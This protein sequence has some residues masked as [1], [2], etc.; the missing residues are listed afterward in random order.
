M[1]KNHNFVQLF[2]RCIFLASFIFQSCSKLQNPIIPG[3][4]K[5]IPITQQVSKPERVPSNLSKKITNHP[6][7]DCFYNSL[8]KGTDM[9]I[10]AAHFAE[11][12]AVRQAGKSAPI[13]ELPS[14]N[15][16]NYLSISTRHN[17]RYPIKYQSKQPTTK[18]RTTKQDIVAKKQQHSQLRVTKLKQALLEK[19][20][21]TKD[22]Y[23]LRF[24]KE[25][26]LWKA[27]VIENYGSLSRTHHLPVYIAAGTD[28]LQVA[29]S[30]ELQQTRL[31]HVNLP[32]NKQP[33]YVYIG[34]VGLKGGGKTKANSISKV[35]STPAIPG[36]KLHTSLHIGT[37]SSIY[38]A[39]CLAD[40][41]PV[42]IKV[43][44][45]KVITEKKAQRFLREFEL[46]QQVHSPYV[47]RYLELKQDPAYGIAVVMED[48]QAVELSTIVPREG[49]SNRDFIEIALQIV[50]GLQAIHD[51]NIIHNDLKPSN[52]VIEPTTKAIKITD[53]NCASTLREEKRTAMPRRTGTLA[54]ISPEQTGRVNRSVDYRTDFYSLGITFYQLL[55]G[56]PPF[57]AKDALGLI[58]QHLAKQPIP[59]HHRK[60]TIALPL[61]QMVMKLLDKEAENRY[62]SC[63]GILHDLRFCL[64]NLKETGTIPEFVLG[65]QDF[66]NKLTL[67]QQLY[68]RE[69][70]IKTLLDAFERVREGKREGLMVTGQPGVGKTILIQ[71][72]QKPIALKQGYFITGKFDQ[73]N[74]NV[75]YSALTQAFNS[76]IQQWLSEDEIRIT[77]WKTRLLVTLGAQAP[78]LTK[79]IPALALLIGEQPDTSITDINQ[80]KNVFNWIF[81]EFIKICAT[82]SHPLVIFLDDLQWAD[83]ASLELMTYL[84][85]Q[86]NIGHLLW[87]G[88]YRDTEITPSHPALQAITTLQEAQI[89]IQKLPLAPLSLASLYQW[90]ADSLH[91]PLID[92]QPLV[93]LIF[94]K[95]AG[96]PF[97]VKL[98]LQS[99]YDQRLLTFSPQTHWKWEL[100]KIY[101]HP[102]T[103]NVITLM[104][105][106]IRQ[107]PVT[108]Q[109]ALSV[110]SCISHRLALSTLQTAMACSHEEVEK[111]LQ[112]ALNSGIL[113][114]VDHEVYFAH[115]RVQEA[116]YHLIAEEERAHTHLTIGQ[117]LLA[118]PTSEETLLLDI[119]AQF[120]RSRLLVTEPK[121]RLR[122]A[123]LNLK[124][125]QKAKKATAYTSALDY[126]YVSRDWIDIET[127]WKTDYPLAFTFHKELA[128]IEYL[129]GHF[130]TSE[131]LIKDMQPWL[132]SN[133]DKVDIFRLLII[134]KTFQVH[135]H[136]AITIGQQAL[137]LLGSSLP[138]DN[139]TEFL[140]REMPLLRQRLAG[141]SFS[142]LLDAPLV[143]KPEKQALFKILESLYSAAYLTGS[144]LY[145]AIAL[146]SIN[147]S[148]NYGHTPESC[149][150][151]AAYGHLLCARFEEYALG[152]QFGNLALQLAEKLQLPVQHCQ[153]S[154]IMLGFIY[155][156][157]K[158]I[159]QLPALLAAAYKSCL[160][161][162]E[163]EFA[164]YCA[165]LTAQTLPYLGI[166]LA[167][168]QQE[169]LPLLQFA[170]NTK[171]QMTANIIQSV[172]RVL[173]NLRGDTP[174]EWNFDTDTIDEAK[175]EE[176]CQQTNS[177]FALCFYYIFKAQTFYLYDD[178]KQAL[179]NL[180]LAKKHLIV[181]TG[182]YIT[183]IF[184][185][186]HSLI[187]LALYP[188]AS[189][190]DQQAY[191]EQVIQNQQQMQRWQASCP[192]NFAHKYLLVEA[193]L[194][195]LKGH[196]EQ[197][198]EYYDQVIELAGQHG[199][200]QE[201]ALAAKLAAKY[202]LARGRSVCAQSYLYITFN[203]YK[204]W[205][206]KH[207][208]MRFKAQ[209]ADLLKALTPP[210]LSQLVVNQETTLNGNTLQYLDLSS[211]LKASYAISSEIE[212]TKLLRS[213]MQIIIENAGA[214][215]GAVLFVEADDTIFVQA[216]Y[217]IDGT[218]TTLQKIP[219]ADWANGAHT[220]IQY[221]KR[222][223]QP[224]VV[225]HATTHEQFKTDLYINRT[226]AK[227]ILC[228]P[229]LK[230]K[231][232]QAI[233]YVENNLMT[234]AFMPE[235]VQT[236]LILTAQM[237]IS[238]ENARYVA[239]QLVLT[240]QL[241][242]QSARR[243]IA[244]ESLHAV[245][246]DLKLALEASQAGTWNWW[247]DTDKVTWDT[248]NCA[249]FG[250]TPDTFKGTYA[251]VVE[252]VHPEDRERLNQCVKRCLEQDIPYDMEYRVIWPDGSQHV[253]VAHGH[254]YR[255][256]D[257]KPIKMVGV[258]LDI[259]Q[260]KQLEQEWLE[261][262]EQ[263]EEAQRQRADEAE[264][265]SEEQRW[266]I[267]TVCHEIRNPMSGIS[268][269]V[270]FMEEKLA[271][272]KAYKKSLPKPAL[273]ELVQTLEED[274][275]TIK[276]CVNHQ[277]AVINGVLSLS[278]LEAGKEELIFEP[279]KPKAIIKDIIT[280]FTPQLK[281]KQLDL[282][283]DLPEQAIAIKGDP[284]RFKIVLINLIS[285]AIKFTEKGYI[286]VS[287]QIQSVDSSHVQVAICVEDTGTG[288][289][290]EE[291]SRLFQQF[292]RPL[293]SQ[294]EGSG[295]GLAIS[296]KL[297][298]L[299]GGTIQVDSVKG[300]GSVFAI[301]L[302]CEIVGIEEKISPLINR[303]TPS[304]LPLLPPVAKHILVV[305]D[306]IVNQKI[307]RR[308]L[309]AAGYTC[310]V[311]DNGQKAIEA[312]GAL[313]EVE[314]PEQWNLTAFD[315]ILMDLE[316]PVMGGIEATG[317][318]RK[319]E[320]QLGVPSIPIIGLSAYAEEVYGE[321]A[322]Q[323][324]MNNYLTKP[325]KREEMFKAIQAY[326]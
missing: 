299:M 113:I 140:Q 287:L 239:R 274:I 11:I 86:P 189:I 63:E 183:A 103:E 89:T 22:R 149:H 59:P 230:H 243:L 192:E 242:E 194:A 325:Y 221:V 26:G 292:S 261:A 111:T 83:Q 19:E 306:N 195:R 109:K 135:Y 5:Q 290:P 121:E 177:F 218:I 51:A 175:F 84:L 3:K 122:I 311:A 223:Q 144:E 210:G 67:S 282:I 307:L 288:M 295:L 188:T 12:S 208:L 147:L 279:F 152:Y 78:F 92:I 27:E 141:I 164:G 309:E 314:M 133:L 259:T 119:V 132:Q 6:D 166:S 101:Q 181:I 198:E 240:Q 229:L 228:V 313:E 262:L 48:D 197:A 74:K 80:A 134:Q 163:L 76:L 213:M 50:Q 305:E 39:I 125:A 158:S 61:S 42:V 260:H 95:T 10:S 193:E 248:T 246:H 64:P 112:P 227:S 291:Q 184:N 54:Y 143:V 263:A 98:F 156:W 38:R 57:T 317:W 255:D 321:K 117:R 120:N 310:T 37:F 131:V 237:E 250:L 102:A 265:H 286:K 79:V 320:K 1:K 323:A 182:H 205:G 115:D 16:N 236:V 154:M 200:I 219:L 277:I 97:F 186:Y 55:C 326:R 8:E 232:L 29:S 204:Q 169:V 7:L 231:E 73:L 190:E 185:W 301:H 281:T 253:I 233:L 216:E 168:V 124:A 267:D 35:I 116:A 139:L 324:G 298:D 123:R 88:A 128:E 249:L 105:Y 226:Q 170:Q 34:S 275:K 176:G 206:A 58:H 257:G 53:F 28:L 178:F 258:C 130:E 66:S 269:T 256:K 161:C 52:I 87:I 49:F 245:T 171:N 268:N 211:I 284:E 56:E 68:G 100:A 234:H 315:L 212:L 138:L 215:Q 214:Q 304:T 110:A 157:S 70:E 153:S 136:E 71:E 148:L 15:L 129:S 302:T 300:Q 264:R 273:E 25:L 296:K 81:Q 224:I 172:Q 174:D 202:W 318:I 45:Q 145:P 151:Y 201:Q 60:P 203:G 289:T 41:H 294:Y 91:K 191:L 160:A 118:N 162:G 142:S 241:A 90:I 244:E 69:S 316:M 96:N 150:S 225:D 32:K 280:L 159:Q 266:F 283:V 179:D 272:L 17:Q 173:A 155:P 85:Q 238:L 209:Y 196:Y 65:Q 2:R 20:I 220:V 114:Q 107:L 31:I 235:Q 14:S 276:H 312:I 165:N 106:Q 319:K 33:G 24:Y 13:Q 308:Q 222:M 127:L 251:A 137:Q 94:Q 297:L 180:A 4:K 9:I 187:Y 247:I 217:A 254:V 77:Q 104:T 199:F 23:Q 322:K 278:R 46:G 93:E 18:T 293:S 99:L 30:N 62:Q 108:T 285:N 146:I 40:N 21:I 207:K 252:C 270:S 167:K 82:T 126:L 43:S 72:I 271:S 44:A 36:Y 303:K 75:A 47:V